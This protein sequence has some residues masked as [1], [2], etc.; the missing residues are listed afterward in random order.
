MTRHSEASSGHSLKLI[1]FPLNLVMPVM[2]FTIEVPQ[3]GRR[4]QTQAT[5]I[6]RSIQLTPLQLD[7]KTFRT[8]HLGRVLAGWMLASSD[9]LWLHNKNCT[10]VHSPSSTKVE[11]TIAKFP[12]SHSK[13][14]LQGAQ[15]LACIYPCLNKVKATCSNS[16]LSL[17]SPTACT[18]HNQ[19]RPL[20]WMSC[21][22]VATALHPYIRSRGPCWLVPWKK[23]GTSISHSK[24]TMSSQNKLNIFITGPTGAF[25][26]VFNMYGANICAGYIGGSV[27]VCL[28]QHPDSKCFQISALVHS[29]TKAEK[30]KTLG[31]RPVLGSYSDLDLLMREAAEADFVITIVHTIK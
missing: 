21:S 11:P 8:Y 4:K 16:A 12:E 18:T 15:Y 25:Y 10:P 28:L 22:S 3:D 7:W 17:K 5:H 23:F 24:L 1:F 20:F 6:I 27:L 14:A 26:C 9:S 30:L 13:N 2:T 31:I 29:S 19:H